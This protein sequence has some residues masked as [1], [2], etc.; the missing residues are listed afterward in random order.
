MLFSVICVFVCRTVFLKGIYDFRHPVK[1][2]SLSLVSK[3]LILNYAM[4]ILVFW[5]TFSFILL[6]VDTF[7][8]TESLKLIKKNENTQF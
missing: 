3:Q 1:V 2:L 5:D 6:T 8:Y 4:V 7:D